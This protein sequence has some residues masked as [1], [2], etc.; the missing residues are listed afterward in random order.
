[1]NC[2]AINTVAKNYTI[3][4]EKGLHICSGIKTLSISTTAS[5]IVERLQLH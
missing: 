2:I 3:I 1:M 4:I 5:K